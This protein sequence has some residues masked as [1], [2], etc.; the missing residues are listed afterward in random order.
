MT[1]SCLL[2]LDLDNTL[3][4][5]TTDCRYTNYTILPYSSMNVHVRPYVR[6]FLLFVFAHPLYEL[7]F[8]TCGTKAYAEEIVNAL[9]NFAGIPMTSVRVLLSRDDATL[10]HG[11]YV[12]DLNI[13]RSR[14]HAP[15]LLLIDDNPIHSW[16]EDN[17]PDLCLIPPFHAH[18]NTQDVFFQCLIAN[19]TTPQTQTSP[20]STLLAA[21]VTAIETNKV[22][23]S[24]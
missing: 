20:Q 24:V 18:T 13:V 10:M 14:F 23:S 4:H 5:S 16:I 8:W 3:V 17:V 6:E 15:H 19:F 12:K 11:T 1:G 21:P 2:V 7:G 9:M 22:H